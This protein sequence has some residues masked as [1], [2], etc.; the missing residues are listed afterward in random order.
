MTSPFDLAKVSFLDLLHSLPPSDSSRLLAWIREDVAAAADD[1]QDDEDAEAVA[2]ARMELTGIAEYIR[3]RVG[4]DGYTI[5][6]SDT[7]CLLK[8]SLS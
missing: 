2:N 6:L 7:P 5:I 1:G 4:I 8:R 3:K